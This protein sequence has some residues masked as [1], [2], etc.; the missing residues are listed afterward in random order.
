MLKLQKAAS[1]LIELIRIGAGVLTNANT[2]GNTYVETDWEDAFVLAQEQDLVGLAYDGLLKV[3]EMPAQYTVPSKSLRLRWGSAVYLQEQVYAKHRKVINGIARW[4][5]RSGIRTLLLKGQGLSLYYPVPEHRSCGDIDLYFCQKVGDQWVCKQDEVDCMFEE[6]LGV[7]PENEK[8]HHSVLHYDGVTIEN[9]YDFV[10]VHSH[11]SNR[12]VESELKALA[13]TEETLFDSNNAEFEWHRPGPMLNAIFLMRHAAGHF[14][15]EHISL[16]HLMDWAFFVRT[17][18]A[19]IDW[20][21]LHQLAESFGCLRFIRAF[22]YLCV[23]LLGIGRDVFGPTY[24][25]E[26]L[27]DAQRLLDDMLT[28]VDFHI[29]DS[30]SLLFDIPSRWKRWSSNRWKYRMVY[31]ENDLVSFFYLLWGHLVKPEK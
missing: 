13:A 5:N 18:Y 4:S 12:Q 29:D 3:Y 22:N 17:E 6:A 19:R 30:K 23:E 8:H 14:A 11:L 31:R 21:K 10:N 7:K 9:H 15:A 20:Q 24:G 16:R 25:N 28:P 26:A 2:V 1:E 27:S